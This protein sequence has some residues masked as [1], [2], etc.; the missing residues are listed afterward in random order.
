MIISWLLSIAFSASISLMAFGAVYRPE[1]LGYLAASPGTLLIAC[2]LPLVLLVRLVEGRAHSAISINAWWLIGYGLVASF[3][4]A[5]FFGFTPLYVTKSATLLVLSAVWLAPLLFF[6]H[7]RI[8]H[9]R[10]A[11]IVALVICAVGYIFG[12]FF[13]GSLPPAVREII[14]GAGYQET[15]DSRAR[16]FMQETSHFATLVGR[17]AMMLY[18]LAEMPRRY[19]A[20][21]QAVFMLF[22]VVLLAVVGSKGAAIS[23]L[24]AFLCIS[25]T[26]RQIPYLLLFAP[27][28]VWVGLQQAQAVAYDLSNFTSGSTRLTLWLAGLAG[29]LSDPIGYGY[30]GFYWAVQHFGGEAMNWL[31]AQ[32]PLNFSEVVDIVEGLNN[33]STKSTLLD[34]LL[35]YGVFFL[36]MMYALCRRINLGDPRARAAVI[37]LLLTSLATSAHESI[38]F[39]LGFVVLIIAFPRSESRPEPVVIRG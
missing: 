33:V 11:L 4:S 31:G 28:V 15:L 38:S 13:S 35:V 36:W 7:V 20:K 3:L 27:V 26:R 9:L 39:F 30:Y 6:D 34:F 10:A 22:L 18:L 32:F 21:R 19:S 2:C 16:G 37:Y 1:M 12:D 8:Q 25:L 14:F 5:L 29:Q 23:I 24:V 17:Y